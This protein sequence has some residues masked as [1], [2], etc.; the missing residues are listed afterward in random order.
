MDLEEIKRLYREHFLEVDK[1]IEEEHNKYKYPCDSDRSFE[2]FLYQNKVNDNTVTED[3]MEWFEYH[4]CDKTG[5]F[6]PYSDFHYYPNVNSYVN[7][8]LN[9]TSL[10]LLVRELNKSLGADRT[11]FVTNETDIDDKVNTLLVIPELY[12]VK[13]ISK[14]CDK[15]MWSFTSVEVDEPGKFMNPFNVETPYLNTKYGY[16]VIR[17]K[18]EPIKTKNITDFVKNK[19]G[20]KIYHICTRE[21]LKWILQSGLRVRGE[22]NYYRYIQNKVYFFCGENKEDLLDNFVEVA[23]SLNALQEEY[24]W[25]KDEFA[26]LEIDVNDYNIDFYM[27]GYYLDQK[28]YIGYTYNYFPPR[29]IKE[30][31]NDD[32]NWM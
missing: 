15:L 12:D 29:R 7:E 9:K 27:D 17:I 13:K 30:V 28:P 23:N 24:D 1:K 16:P 31:D 19:C 2:S 3:M 11:H 22:K 18:V 21:N 25:I 20:G 10:D 14:T 6:H 5:Y 32:L 4:V 26:L 8:M